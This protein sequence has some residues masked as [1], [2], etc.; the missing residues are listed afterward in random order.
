[1]RVSRGQLSIIRYLRTTIAGALMM[2]YGSGYASDHN[3]TLGVHPYLPPNEIVKRFGPLAKYIGDQL[4]YSV[5]IEISGSYE[6]H[7]K[8]VGEGLYDVAFMGPLNY[9]NTTATYGAQPLLGRL[10][11]RGKPYFRGK[12]FTRLNSPIRTL[13]DLMGQRFAYGNKGSTMSYLVPRYMLQQAGIQTK[14]LSK[15]S[16]EG[17]HSNVVRAVLTGHADAGAVK[18]TVFFKNH[19]MLKAIASTQQISE[20]VFVA[21]KALAKDIRI[22]L[23]TALGKLSSSLLGRKAMRSI[24]PSMTGIVS[25]SDEDY[26]NLREILNSLK[27]NG[28][29]GNH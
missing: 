28:S 1:M 22:K 14:D 25:V 15:I 10:E 29:N 7:I 8:A 20:H 12:I 4:G 18:E 3:L 11:I 2:M 26:D 5:K 21:N 16:F 9:V 17:N 27:M 19:S 6:E 13:A 23:T 24:K